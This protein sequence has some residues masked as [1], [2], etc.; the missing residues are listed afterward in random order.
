MKRARARGIARIFPAPF[1]GVR[2]GSV[3]FIFLS[4]LLFLASSLTPG[5]TQAVRTGFVDLF[6]PL[7]AAV[8]KPIQGIS[9]YIETAS[10]LAALQAEN[11]RLQQ[12]N[13]RLRE[14][15]QIALQFQA[16]NESLEK[17]LNVAVEPQNKFVTARVIAD[18]GNTYVKTMLVM[19]GRKHGVDK[20]QA[21][22]SGDG[23]VGRT[24]EVGE[25]TARVLLLTDINARVPVF[26]GAENTRAILSG[27]NS[28]TPLLAHLPPDAQIQPGERVVT[29]GHGGIFPYGMPVGEVIALEDGRLAVS[30]YADM[31]RMI[32]VRIVE[33]NDDPNLIQGPRLP[34]STGE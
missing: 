25:R 32:H 20:G 26:I 11:T 29:S 10:G 31:D 28:N 8:N 17:L 27:T 33:R 12:E 2:G 15:Y 18:S 19:A 9:G 34:A 22:L 1:A 5:R 24:I 13:A 23:L 21:V 6:A 14:W 4:V 7:M 30:M 16:K 3:V